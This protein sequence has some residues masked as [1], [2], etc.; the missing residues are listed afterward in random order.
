MNTQLITRT[1][2]TM[3]IT[4]IQD[5]EHEIWFKGHDVASILGYAKTRNAIIQHV[6]EEDKVTLGD[7]K[8]ALFYGP[9]DNKPHTIFI[10]EK[11]VR[12][13]VCKSKLP[14]A[15][16]IAKKL[17]IDTNNHKYECK[18]S[19][20]CGAIMKAFK[21]ENMKTQYKVD[22]YRIDLYFPD[23]NL[24]V[25]CDEH[26]HKDR[27]QSKEKKR[28]KHITNKLNCQWLRFNPDDK[29]FNIFDVINRIYLVIRTIKDAAN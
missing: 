23:F 5:D 28:Q 13:L 1:F 27:S 18:E 4:M 26:G 11:G 9:L 12:S 24:A 8:G 6:E 2:E 3:D 22:N 15:V 17:G 29:D 21:G 16:D 19:E 10:N 14:K 25:E 7:M 20:S